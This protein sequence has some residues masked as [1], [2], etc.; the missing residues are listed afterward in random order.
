M[1][2]S[3]DEMIEDEKHNPW[4]VTNLDEFLYYC[5]PECDNRTQSKELFINHAYL[6][7]SRVMY[8]RDLIQF[9]G[10]FRKHQIEN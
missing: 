5:C 3:D 2:L 10:Q 8:T 4:S 9:L 7:H 1:E 6:N